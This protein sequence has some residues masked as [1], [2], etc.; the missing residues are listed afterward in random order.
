M[1][2]S[3]NSYESPA[4]GVGVATASSPDGPWIKSEDNPLL[5]FFDGHEGVGHHALFKDAEGKNCIVF[6][7]HNRPGRIHPRITH[8]GFYCLNKGKIIISDDYITP[9]MK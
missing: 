7:S 5:Q 9:I 6:H 3:A 8:I 1:T 4:Y 2:Y